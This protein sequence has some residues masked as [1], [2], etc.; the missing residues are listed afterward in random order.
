MHLWITAPVSP[1]TSQYVFGILL[2]VILVSMG[3]FFAWRQGRTL[4]GLKSRN[5]LTPEDRRFTRNQA[6]RR[7]V[8]SVLLVI[9]AG[10]LAAHFSLEGRA[11]KL[12]A[13]GEANA[14]RGEKRELT[15]EEKEFFN[16]YSNYWLVTLLVLL[17]VITLAGVDLVAL[18][19]Y[20]RRHYQQIQADRRE[21]IRDELA[22]L[23]SRHN[24]RGGMS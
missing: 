23:K 15:P 10:L 20:G 24:G 8:C 21:M 11:N 6:W 7:L 22:R 2:I 18:R 5:D 12:V 14:E 13:L 3:S 1:T 4:V 17:S 9:L 19:R 16:L